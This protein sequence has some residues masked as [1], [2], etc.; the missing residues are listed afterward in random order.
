MGPMRLEF[1]PKN[2][3]LDSGPI[4][5]IIFSD[6]IR[7][8]I[9]SKIPDN[10]G[11]ILRIEVWPDDTFREILDRI[12]NANGLRHDKRMHLRFENDENEK[13]DNSAKVSYYLK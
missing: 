9:K 11:Q 5:W 8:T 4:V 2:V 7:L 1:D 13:I 10:F 3:R 12:A 6:M